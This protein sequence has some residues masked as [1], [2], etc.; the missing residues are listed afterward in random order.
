[1]TDANVENQNDNTEVPT[2]DAKND[3]KP[4]L[5]T[6]VQARL[7]E[8]LKDIKGKLDKAYGVRDEALK[9]IAEFEQEKKKAELERLKEEGKH[10][11][12]YELQLAEERAQKETLLKRNIELTRDI[13]LR[14][15]LSAHDFRNEN[16][17]EMAF[18]EV[19]SGLIQNEEGTWI[20]KSGVSIR[21]FVNAYVNHEDHSFLLRPK[22]SSG[23]GSASVVSVSS[24]TSKKSLFE[25]SQ[26]E[27]LKLAREGKL[28]R[29]TR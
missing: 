28:P 27:V 19:V 9:K 8:A 18:R 25:L 10:K 29:Q 17:S 2:S 26:D 1:M 11:E 3:A 5:E 24:E 13:E 6:I 4:D 22:V 12:A 15:A 21:E 16:A 20:H 23:S 7:E 14:N